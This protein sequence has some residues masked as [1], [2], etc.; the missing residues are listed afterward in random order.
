MKKRWRKQWESMTQ[1]MIK[2]LDGIEEIPFLFKDKMLKAGLLSF[3]IAVIGTYMGVQFEEASFLILTWILAVF[4]FYQIFKFLKIGKTGEYEIMEA[5]VLAVKGKHYPGR[6][7]QIVVQDKDGSQI[8]IRMQK[9]K[10]LMVGKTYRFYFGKVE[11]VEG[12][13]AKIGELMY[14][15]FTGQ[16]KSHRKNGEK[17]VVRTHTLPFVPTCTK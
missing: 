3:F 9:E 2:N 1:Y 4:S 11:R 10:N 5:Q 8:R 14:E 12:K 13:A 17:S 6:M 15:V 7:Y 16:K